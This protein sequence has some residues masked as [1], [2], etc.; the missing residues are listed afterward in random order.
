MMGGMRFRLLNML[1]TST[2]PIGK[3]MSQSQRHVYVK[4]QSEGEIHISKGEITDGRE[5]WERS[6]I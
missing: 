6:H 3:Y 4:Q 5:Q 1:P 2:G